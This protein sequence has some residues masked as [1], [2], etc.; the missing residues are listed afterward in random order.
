MRLFYRAE[1]MGTSAHDRKTETWGE[2]LREARIRALLSQSALARRSDVAR[3]AVIRIEQGESVPTD[4][5][6]E[7]LARAVG[8]DRDELFP[9]ELAPAKASA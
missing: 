6:R 8:M 4:V 2:R 9:P 1:Y 7:R 5:T 3:R